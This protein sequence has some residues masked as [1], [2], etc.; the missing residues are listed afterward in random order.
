M[1]NIPI[2]I[3]LWAISFGAA[4]SNTAAPFIDTFD[5]PF[6]RYTWLTTHNAFNY[7]FTP[8]PNQTYRIP[9]QL[10]DGVR[11][12]MLDFV[13]SRGRIYLCHSVCLSGE[14]T[15]E[16]TFNEQIM[17]FLRTHPDAI[18][19]LHV[20]DGASRSM[21]H[22]AL[23]G[24][25]GLASMTFDPQTWDT[26]DWPTPRQMIGA[27]QRLLIFNLNSDNSGDFAVDEGN[28][29]IMASTDGTVENYWSLGDT[30]FTHDYTCKSRWSDIPL[31]RKNV[32]FPGK[33]WNRLFVMNQFHGVSLGLHARLDNRF[34]R[35]LDRVDNYCAI[36]AMRKPNFIAVDHYEQG[37]GLAFS[38]VVTQGGVIFYRDNAAGGDIV[39]G[40]PGRV[41]IDANIKNGD[42]T[43][44]ENDEARSARI[45]NLPAGTRISVY[46]SPDGNTSDDYTTI[47]LRKD[48]TNLIVPSF[49]TT[50]TNADWEIT[51]RRKN[52]LDGKISRIVIDPPSS[53]P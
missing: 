40:V 47:V 37:D 12:L 22:T 33:A 25:P 14:L 1:R 8:V 10:R 32:A 11:G 29:H 30:I 45:A 49:E 24:V 35:L 18:L 39:C 51:Y 31:D 28:V 27:G 5:L 21:L 42:F 9:E 7:G 43:G 53:R 4:A 2:S 3:L 19:T 26:P 23:N 38:G 34:D 17:P 13:Q 52:G 41:H 36:P 6:D 48:V 44:C 46:D 16:A 20:E 50:G 15:L